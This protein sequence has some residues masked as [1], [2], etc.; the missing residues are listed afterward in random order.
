MKKQSKQVLYPTAVI[1]AMTVLTS[2]SGCGADQNSDTTTDNI[3]SAVQTSSSQQSGTVK[4][5]STEEAAVTE[6]TADDAPVSEDNNAISLEEDFVNNEDFYGLLSAEYAAS[7]YI[8]FD[9]TDIRSMLGLPH[10]GYT[11]VKVCGDLVLYDGRNTTNDDIV[12]INLETKSAVSLFNQIGYNVRD[13]ALSQKYAYLSTTNGRI[14]VFNA[15]GE[16]ENSVDTG[17]TQL[18]WAPEGAAVYGAAMQNVYFADETLSNAKQIEIPENGVMQAIYGPCGRDLMAFQYDIKSNNGLTTTVR[19]LYDMKT[20]N[21]QEIDEDILKRLASSPL[22]VGK[23]FITRVT[24]DNSTY[25]VTIYDSE[26][27]KPVSKFNAE[28][29]YYSFFDTYY[30]GDSNV[31]YNPETST[32]ER[33]KYGADCAKTVIAELGKHE[34]PEDKGRTTPDKETLYFTQVSDKYYLASQDDSI[35]L[36]T[37]EGGADS[38]ELIFQSEE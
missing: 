2:L 20:M 11:A 5:A 15:N 25:D 8:S 27:M 33:V 14:F 19:S 30:G 7:G 13:Y 38:A 24:N 10:A 37:Y 29:D 35:Y 36:C 31:I 9:D 1:L 18:L 34:L 4:T 17:S 32:W 21:C 26:S 22:S 28:S 16:L 12:L 23:Y 6:G 3:P